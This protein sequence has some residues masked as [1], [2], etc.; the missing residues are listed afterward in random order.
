M[1]R[2][3]TFAVL[4]AAGA[5]RAATVSDALK[6][7]FKDGA[8]SSGWI[9]FKVYKASAIFLPAKLNGRDVMVSLYGGPTNLDKSFAASIGLSQTPGGNKD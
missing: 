8:S 1:F 2:V 5:V 4:L 3:L 9:V 6:V 7:V